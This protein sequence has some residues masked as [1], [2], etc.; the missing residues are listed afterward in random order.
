MELSIVA[1]RRRTM[2]VVTRLLARLAA[3]LI[4]AGLMNAAC[5]A[6]AGDRAAPTDGGPAATGAAG[7]WRLEFG[8]GNG[9]TTWMAD[10]VVEQES[11]AI[12]GG[13]TSG[14]DAFLTWRGQLDGDRVVFT[15]VPQRGPADG[16]GRPS[17]LVFEGVLRETEGAMSGTWRTDSDPAGETG[18]FTATRARESRGSRRIRQMRPQFRG[19]SRLC[20][21]M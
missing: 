11:T 3:M 20:S 10:C 12:T 17:P 13:C 14:F 21:L 4:G 1:N 15:L 8:P 2:E 5:S 19:V 9:Q 7:T 16:V 6:P 18:V